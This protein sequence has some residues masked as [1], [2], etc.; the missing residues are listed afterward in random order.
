[1]ERERH[2]SLF[3][4][5]QQYRTLFQ[6]HFFTT[7]YC[8]PGL[9]SNNQVLIPRQSPFYLIS[10]S[11]HP[12]Q[13]DEQSLA[14]KSL[15]RGVIQRSLTMKH[16]SGSP[17]P[18]LERIFVVPLLLATSSPSNAFLGQIPPTTTDSTVTQ[19]I[20]FFLS[21]SSFFILVSSARKP[22]SGSSNIFADNPKFLF[23]MSMK[24]V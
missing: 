11:S 14:R 9:C 15:K 1:M 19:K 10:L 18:Q 16:R 7:R 24:S 17:I 13:T 8:S 2:Q 20:Q 3:L 12:S 6:R 23:S 5:S 4:L 21:L 22:I